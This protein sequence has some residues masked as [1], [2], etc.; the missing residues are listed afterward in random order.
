MSQ[1][2]ED[3]GMNPEKLWNTLHT[4]S[5]TWSLPA[6][7]IT[8]VEEE[9]ELCPWDQITNQEGWKPER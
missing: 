6:N 2:T 9:A 8:A 4:I 3:F 5:G 1:E 7:T